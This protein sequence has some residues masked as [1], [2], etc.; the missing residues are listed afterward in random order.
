MRVT[1]QIDVPDKIDIEHALESVSDAMYFA[2][3]VTADEQE[4][5]IKIIQA[6]QKQKQNEN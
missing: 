5:V 2:D 6:I 3:S 4:L 1:I